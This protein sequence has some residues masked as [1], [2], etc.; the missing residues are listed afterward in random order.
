MPLRQLKNKDST[1]HPFRQISLIIKL[2]S[3][4]RERS[5]LSINDVKRHKEQPLSLEEKKEGE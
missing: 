5:K 2:G 4:K 3:I 1:R